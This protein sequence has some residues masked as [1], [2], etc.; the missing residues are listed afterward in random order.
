[1]TIYFQDYVYLFSG[2]SNNLFEKAVHFIADKGL[3]VTLASCF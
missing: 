1:M 3:D 2:G